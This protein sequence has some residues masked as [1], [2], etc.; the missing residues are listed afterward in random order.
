MYAEPNTEKNFQGRWVDIGIVTDL[1]TEE[2]TIEW[3]DHVYADT[4]LSKDPEEDEFVYNGSRYTITEEGHITREAEFGIYP[5]D[6]NED[7]ETLG[8]MD[9]EG[10]EQHNVRHE[11]V[12]FV[13]WP[14]A[15]EDDEEEAIR[16]LGENARVQAGDEELA[17]G[18]YEMQFEL[19]IEGKY[20]F[21]AE[22]A[23]Q[24]GTE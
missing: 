14:N 18:P 19:R 16:R 11:A 22:G 21:D 13:I 15:E 20:W 3:L 23:L 6:E 12:I 17:D 1:G 8:V 2:E 4:T 10:A 5:D 7:L 9:E 24:N